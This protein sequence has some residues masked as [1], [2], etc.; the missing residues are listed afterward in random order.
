[1]PVVQ[2]T[3][4]GREIL[5]CRLLDAGARHRIRVGLPYERFVQDRLLGPLGME[6]TSFD[7]NE[8]VP[9]PFAPGHV[10]RP[11]DATYERAPHQN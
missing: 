6:R 7:P 9:V 3:D 4:D 2:E 5:E 8:I 1:M 11:H 10:V